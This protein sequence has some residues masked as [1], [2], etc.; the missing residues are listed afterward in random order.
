MR[1]PLP[2]YSLHLAR[3][4]VKERLYL[5]MHVCVCA[6]VCVTRLRYHDEAQKRV[7]E[8][9]IAELETRYK[10]KIATT[11]DPVTVSRVTGPAH[12]SQLEYNTCL[13]VGTGLALQHSVHA[14][15]GDSCVCVC[16]Y[17]CVCV[18][19]CVCALKGVDRCR[20]LPSGLPESVC[21]QPLVTDI[22]RAYKPG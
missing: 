12:L 7:A 3:C 14:S 11:L 8:S 20:R 9:M 1:L 22:L 13:H 17:I 18:C 2:S 16:M 19:A 10:C 21:H 6:C 15:S 5:C 4:N